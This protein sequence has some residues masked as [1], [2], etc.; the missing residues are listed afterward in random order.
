MV[1]FRP[2]GEEEVEQI[3][4]TLQS[5]GNPDSVRKLSSEQVIFLCLNLT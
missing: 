5:E 2:E 4:I 1:F 3:Q